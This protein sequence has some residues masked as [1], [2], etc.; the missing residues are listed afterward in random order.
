LVDNLPPKAKQLLEDIQKDLQQPRREAPE[1]VHLIIG[2]ARV[3]DVLISILKKVFAHEVPITKESKGTLHD[4]IEY[5]RALGVITIYEHDQLKSLRRLRNDAA[6]K[7]D[8]SINIEPYRRTVMGLN[9]DKSFAAECGY[10]VK[11]PLQKLQACVDQLLVTLRRRLRQ[12]EMWPPKLDAWLG[13]VEEKWT[14]KLSE[15]RER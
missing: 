12:V 1:I 7:P 11:Q 6:H 8:F 14:A 9:L 4:R 13:E 15:V 5:C 2:M 3:D 10:D